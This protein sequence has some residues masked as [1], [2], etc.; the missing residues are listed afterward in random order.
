MG[1]VNVKCRGRGKVE[2]RGAEGGRYVT[3]DLQDVKIQGIQV[4]QAILNEA[5]R[6][7]SETWREVNIPLDVSSIDY[8]QGGARVV[9]KRKNSE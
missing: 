2:A 1:V 8:W 4:P 7:F 5:E 9:F 6:G 3:L